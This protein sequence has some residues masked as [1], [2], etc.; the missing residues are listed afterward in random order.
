MKAIL[1]SDRAPKLLLILLLLVFPVAVQAQFTYTNG[2]ETFGYTTNGGVITITAYTGF[3]IAVTIPSKIGNLTVTT[4]GVQAFDST[5][6]VSVTIPNGVTSIEDYAFHH[7]TSLTS[8]TIPNSVTNLGDWAFWA[9][10]R[11]TNVIIGDNIISIGYSVFEDC[12]LTRVTFGTRVTSIGEYAF[13]NCGYLPNITIPNSVTTIKDGAFSEC[14]DL[15]NITISANVTNIGSGAFGSC[16][17][18]IGMTIPKSVTSIGDKAFFDCESLTSITVNSGNPAY[19]SVAGV[20]FN[21]SQTTLLAYPVASA[22]SSYTI[23]D[24]VTNIADFTFRYSMN[25]TNVTIGTNVANIGQETF[26]ECGSLTIV[27]IGP[28]VTNIDYGAFAGCTSLIKAYFEGNAPSLGV[29]VFYPDNNATIY[30]LPGTAGWDPSFGW[31]PAVL[32]LPQIQTSDA[33]FGLR[34]NRFGFNFNWASGR[35]VV[36]EASTNLLNPGWQAVQTNSLSTR[37]AYFSDPQWT[38]YP[39]RFYRLRS[40]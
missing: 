33:G 13:E 2:N 6:V 25:L 37:S 34:T 38:N 23:P 4:I 22:V 21:K 3:G 17:S 31:I 10:E 26:E 9:C 35:T 40:P 19:A 16:I 18:L 27:T 28:S 11:M 36:V 7:C 39:G 15:T 5:M 29:D 8:M 30:Y 20:L 12:G 32:W 24:S 1:E 14:Y